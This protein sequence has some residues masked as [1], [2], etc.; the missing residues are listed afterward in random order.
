MISIRKGDTVKILVGKDR[1]KTGK[2]IAVFPKR[3]RA[4]VEGR[5]IYFRH[6]RPKKAGEKGQK[7]QFPRALD[8]SNLM[9]I[10]PHCNK[11]TK[12]GAIKDEKGVKVRVCKNCGK[13]I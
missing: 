2:V 3:S 9:L 11:A 13:K 12:I 7:I 6:K 5:N 8:I 1:D 10:C 4:I